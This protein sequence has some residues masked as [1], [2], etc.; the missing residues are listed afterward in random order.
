MIRIGLGYDIHRLAPGRKL[1]L[2]GVEVD[3]PLG[4]EGHSDA[5]VVLHAIADALL[6]AAALGDIGRHFPPSAE[7]WRN[8]SSLQILEHVAGLLS[9][10]GFRVG[11]VDVVVVAEMPRLAP[12]VDLMRERIAEVLQ[13]PI[14][15]VGLQATTNE[16]MGPEGRGEAISARAVALLETAR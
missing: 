7:R 16:G 10:H 12:Y 11:N 5:D 3:F 9:E 1:V 4:L 15:A 14:D 2:G 8:V 13:I 6:G